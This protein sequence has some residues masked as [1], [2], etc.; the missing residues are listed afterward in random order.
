VAR[1]IILLRTPV[2]TSRKPRHLS[3]SSNNPQLSDGVTDQN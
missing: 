3:T 2:S 1:D